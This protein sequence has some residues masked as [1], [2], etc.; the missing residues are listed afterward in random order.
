MAIF[1]CL[2]YLFFGLIKSDGS[3]YN[4][5]NFLNGNWGGFTVYPPPKYD[6]TQSQQMVIAQMNQTNINWIQLCFLWGQTNI[7]STSVHKLP[8]TPTD[9]Q[10]ISIINYAHSKNLKVVL[11]P[12]V[13]PQDGQWRGAIGKY[14]PSNS[15]QWNLWFQN[16][17]NMMVYYAQ[18]AQANNVEMYSVGFEYASTVKQTDQWNSVIQAVRNVYKGVKNV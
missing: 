13:N 16:Y 4:G 8:N 5:F 15:N 11:R 3:K 9:S 1:L 17:T 18:L 7:N 12:G 10:L 6:S 14:W 2:L